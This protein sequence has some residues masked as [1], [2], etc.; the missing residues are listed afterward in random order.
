MAEPPP[1][2][3]VELPPH[4]LALS[5]LVRVLGAARGRRVFDETLASAE[6]TT[7]TTAEEL[8]VF[9]EALARH[10]GGIE[11]AV[12]AMLGVSAVLRGAKGRAATR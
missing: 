5:K 3:D 4:A 2:Q 6:L 9:S 12:G 10:P 11:A 1:T 8:F 7:I